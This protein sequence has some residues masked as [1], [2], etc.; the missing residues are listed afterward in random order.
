MTETS[1]RVPPRS[2]R[3]LIWSRGLSDDAPRRS[4]AS[5]AAAGSDMYWRTSRP[6]PSAALVRASFCCD[7]KSVGIETTAAVTDLPR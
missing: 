4:D 2:A 6:A 1:E 3:T 7:V 5:S